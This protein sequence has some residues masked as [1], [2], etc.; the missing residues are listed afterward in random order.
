M[1]TPIVAGIGGGRTDT[2]EDPFVS[3]LRPLGDREGHAGFAAGVQLAARAAIPSAP[4]R[5]LDAPDLV[6]DYYLNLISWS[7]T[8]VLAVALNTCVYLWNAATNEVQQLLSLNEGSVD[9]AL[10]AQLPLPN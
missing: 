2:T 9:Q 3:P 6:D 4:V 10:G 8:N 7:S 1:P 5:I